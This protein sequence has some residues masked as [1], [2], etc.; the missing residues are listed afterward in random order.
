MVTM[1]YLFKRLLGMDM[2]AMMR[3]EDGG[4][5]DQGQGDQPKKKKK[6]SLLDGI[7]GMIPH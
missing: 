7:G 6:R 2:N 5:D 4:R 3:G 1:P